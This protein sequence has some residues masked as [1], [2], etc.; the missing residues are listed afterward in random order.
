[1]EASKDPLMTG[2]KLPPERSGTSPYVKSIPS[3]R[4][5]DLD[6][7][8]NPD[9]KFQE[10]SGN[11]RMVSFLEALKAGKDLVVEAN[12]FCVDKFG[13]YEITKVKG[14]EKFKEAMTVAKDNTDTLERL[15]EAG[16][17]IRKSSEA[18]T[19]EEKKFLETTVFGSGSFDTG[20]IANDA[21][22][23]NN[24]GF[25][26]YL[27]MMGGPF[28]KQLYLF[29]YLDMHRKSFEAWNHN[30]IAH[31][32]CKV[33]TF[34][35]LGDGIKWKCRDPRA[36]DIFEKFAKNNKL[37]NNIKFWS[38]ML[39]R[40]GEIMLRKHY[41]I[42]TGD[43]KL[44]FVD[45]STVWEI[46]TDPEDID[47]VFYYWQQYPT[48][49]QNIYSSDNFR[50]A[51]MS[52]YVIN[53]IPAHE[54]IHRKINCSPNEKRGRSELFP[55]LGWL[56]RYKDFWTAYVLRKIVQSTFAWKNKIKGSQ[57]D[58]DRFVSSFG[59]QVP[60]FGGMWVENE[61]SELTPMTADMAGA[62][63]KSQAEGIL[64][65]IAIGVGLPKE[66]L[67]L[68]DASTRATALVSSEPGAKKFQDWQ[69]M[70]EDLLH[71]IA[72]CVFDYAKLNN[73]LP[74]DA[75]CTIEFTFPEI[76]YEDRSKKIA[77]ISTAEANKWITHERAA[78]MGAKMLA[79]T[80]YDWDK[81]KADMDNE[82]NEWARVQ[83]KVVSNPI[84][85]TMD[86]AA[87][88]AALNPNGKPEEEKTK[89]GI[90]S[91]ERARAEQ[92]K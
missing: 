37:Q 61:A 22:A 5:L 84:I 18:L 40:D 25:N 20:D 63:S 45:P 15:I 54:I 87:I 57:Q 26:E 46:I 79:I 31:Q 82:E 85:D 58:V 16:V 92:L 76:A 3:S 8:Y 75:D 1:M 41:N 88:G 60:T 56:K 80:E 7:V 28:S 86:K 65:M 72:D 67:G 11:S 44:K 35:A 36:Q 21:N 49:Y 47:R 71:E 83:N 64:A 38:T 14:T 62:D 43:I 66:Y 30:P 32:I 68:G 4:V 51:D 39:A 73:Q 91:E 34:F 55:V 13:R 89:S 33:I 17:R 42:L 6:S 81:E 52:K 10:Q 29:D 69:A 12:L 90:S 74:K 19:D 50:R 27:P 77:D 70:F 48:Q 23:N 24:G 78:T 2:G 9:K 53:Q 59:T